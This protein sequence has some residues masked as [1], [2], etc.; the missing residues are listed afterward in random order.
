[1]MNGV[2]KYSTDN[3]A[4]NEMIIAVDDVVKKDYDS[5]VVR[6][7]KA[8][9]RLK[10]TVTW[11]NMQ[12]ISISWDWYMSL[13]TMSQKPLN[14]IW[15]ALPRQKLSA[16]EILRLWFTVISVQAIARWE[17]IRKRRDISTMPETNMTVPQKNLK[18]V[19][20]AGSCLTI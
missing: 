7:K 13:R 4:D 3:I 5:A 2:D 17:E 8:L 18:N 16:R 15:R 12:S 1:M 11:K 14:V 9:A 10:S 20:K 19:I 6:I